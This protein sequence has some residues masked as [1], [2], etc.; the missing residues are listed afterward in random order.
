MFDLAL[1]KLLLLSLPMLAALRLFVILFLGDS[2]KHAAIGAIC[3]RIA[4]MEFGR[5]RHEMDVA[6]PS[7]SVPHAFR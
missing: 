1:V 5:H 6:R 7:D 4:S 2:Q 3:R